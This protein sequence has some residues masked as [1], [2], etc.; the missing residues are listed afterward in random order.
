MSEEGLKCRRK[1]SIKVSAY[2]TT[3]KKVVRE[4]NSE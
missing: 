4:K 1:L 2:L 3:L